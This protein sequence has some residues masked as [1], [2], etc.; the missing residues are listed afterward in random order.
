MTAKGYK[1]PKDYKPPNWVVP[2]EVV[3][4]PLAPESA[5]DEKTFDGI[6]IHKLPPRLRRLPKNDILKYTKGPGKIQDSS[7]VSKLFTQIVDFWFLCLIF[8]VFKPISY[9]LLYAEL[10]GLAMWALLRAVFHDVLPT[11][12]H[13]TRRSAWLLWFSYLRSLV[14]LRLFTR[15]VV[16][17]SVEIHTDRLFDQSFVYRFL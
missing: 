6:D 3:E 13:R 12:S 17:P 7:F 10:V 2:T 9:T 8:L 4:E 16:G 1:P 5:N 14:S 11:F 15:A